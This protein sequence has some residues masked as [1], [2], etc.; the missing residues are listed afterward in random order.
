M[1]K[2]LHVLTL[3][4]L[5]CLIALSGCSFVSSDSTDSSQN[6]PSGS[7]S[8]LPDSFTSSENVELT[9]QNP[10]SRV[11]LSVPD[12]IDKVERTSVAIIMENS[13]ATSAGSGV[14]VNID[15]GDDSN[16]LTEF[17]IIT[18]HHVVSDGGDISV[19]IPDSEGRDYGDEGYDESFIFTGNIDNSKSN[20][21]AVSLVGGDKDSDVAVLKV[22]IS[23]SEITADDIVT[24]EIPADGYTLREGDT[25]VAIG[26]PTGSLPGSTSVGTVGHMFRNT[27]ID[28]VG[29]MTLMQ[30]NVDIYPGSSGGGLH[31]LYGELVGITSAGDTEHTGINFAIPLTL[32]EGADDKGFVNIASQLVATATENNHGYVSGRWQLGISVIEAA[33][34][35]GS[36]YLYVASVVEN[37]CSDVAGINKGDIISS[38]TYGGKEYSVNTLTKFSSVVEQMKS[39]LALGNTFIVHVLRPS[40]S[41]FNI[42]YTEMDVTV[43]LRQLIFCDTGI[44]P[45][46]A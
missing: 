13:A 35:D 36:S 14:L 25:V 16:N 33:N 26:N 17:Y 7:I 5:V 43:T 42:T 34:R 6:S 1:K 19:Y 18:C 44:Y 22:D 24:A 8:N 21:G 41:G 9:P 30:I 2:F 38:I 15:D 4:L 37:G 39:D 31:N 40:G 20:D 28:E 11:E 27:T 10:D 45:E 29:E 3:S 23:D 32:T 46:A 12:L